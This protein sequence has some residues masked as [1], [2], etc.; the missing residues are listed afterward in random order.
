LHLP[1]AHRLGSEV[2]TA[3]CA[4]DY[5]LSPGPSPH[6]SRYATTFQLRSVWE[7]EEEI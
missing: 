7:T 4:L 2:D 6:T 5:H 1:S 3:I